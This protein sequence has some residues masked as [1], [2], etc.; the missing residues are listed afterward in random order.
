MGGGF[1]GVCFIIIPE[2]NYILSNYQIL[3][4]ENV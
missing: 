3:Y 2:L 4:D 1:E